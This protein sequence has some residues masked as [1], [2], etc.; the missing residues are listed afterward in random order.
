MFLMLRGKKHKDS[1]DFD[2][3][4]ALKMMKNSRKFIKECKDFIY[5]IVEDETDSEEEREKEI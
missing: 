2:W 1:V 3:K 5:N 4:I